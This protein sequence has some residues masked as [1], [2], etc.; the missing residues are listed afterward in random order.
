[1]EITKEKIEDVVAP[2]PNV[3]VKVSLNNEERVKLMDIVEQHARKRK[4]AIGKLKEDDFFC[5]AMAVFFA[6]GMEPPPSWV[7]G[8]MGNRPEMYGME[9]KSGRKKK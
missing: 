6:L 4:A 5:G 1:M 3:A 7:F 2:D 9:A 8:I